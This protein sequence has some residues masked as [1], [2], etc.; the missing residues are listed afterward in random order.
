MWHGNHVRPGAAHRSNRGLE[1]LQGLGIGMKVF[2]NF[3]YFLFF[4]N[5]LL[6]LG[7][8]LSRLL[9]SCLLGTWL[10][11]RIDRTI[12]QNG[13][14]GAD[15]GF[16][17]WIGMLYVDHYH[18]NPVL[19]SFCHILIT[20]HKEKK[21][22]QTTKYW[23]LN[24]S[25][26][27]LRICALRGGENRPP[28]RVRSSSEELELRHQSSDAFPGRRLPG[29]GI[30]PADKMSS[31]GKVT[32]V[33]SGK[34]YQQIFQAEVQL[35]H[36]LAATRKRAAEH[37]VTLKCGKIPMMKKVETPEGEVMSPRQQKW[38][39]S[40]PNNWIME[41]PVLHR[42][43]E[44]AKRE[45]ARESEST[46]AAREV[47]G[48]MDTVVPEK[49]S[50][51]TFQRRAEHKRRSFENALASFQE[52]IAQVGKEM[53]AL[54]VDTA[55]LFLKKL[56]ESDEE[57][58]RL[59]L[60]MEN[61]T[62]LEDYTI[63]ALLELWDK[64]ARQFLLQKQE[65]KELDE[66]L[67]SLEFS[68]VN[69]LKG[70]LKKYAEVIEKTSYLMRPDVYKLIN[71]EAMVMN[72]ALL[73][74]RKALAQL[75]VNLMES[76]LQQ[77]LDIRHRWQSLVDTWKDLKK[78]A[79]LQSFSE[80]MASESIHTPLAVV[81]ELEVML[82]TQN[83]LQQK[84]LKHLCTICDLLPPNYSKTQLTEWHS[85]L[86]SMNKELDTYHVDCMMRIRLLYEKTWQECLMLVQNCKKQLLD[87]KAFTE[88][89]AETLVNQF[90]FQMVGAL[91]GKVEEDLEL[92]DKSFETLADQTEWQSS[93]LFRYFQ[94]AV[95]LWEA[96][97]KEL[98]V[99]ELELEKRMEQHQQKH[100]LESQVQEA[101]LDRLLDQLRQQSDKEI[102][103]FHLEKVKDYLKNMK[104]RYE[105]FHTLLTKEVMEY[106]AIILKE[107]NSYSS[108]LSQYFFVREIFEQ[109]LAGEVIFKFRQPE[110][111][112][113]PFQ[114]RMRKL[115]KKQGSKEDM[116]RSEES[117]SSG[118]SAATSVEEMEEE[119]DQEM[120]SFITEEV[121]GQQ[122][123]FPLHAEMDES[124]EG[125]I[126]GLEEMQVERES[127]LNPSLNEENVKG[128]GEEKEESQEEDEKEEEEEEKLE[129]EKEEK[130]A[131][132]EQESLS[133]GEEEDKEEGLE[134]TYYEDMESF[135]VSSG[136]TYF[137]FVPLEE[138]EHC[139]KSHSTFSAMF[140]S[141]TSSAKFIE[142]VTIPSRLILEIK[143]QLRA[144]FFE[145]LEKWFDQCSLN[146]RVTVATKINELDSELELHLHLHQ[147]RAQQI[148]KDIHNV[149]AA[150]L[151]LHQE[152]L[153]S[154]CAGVTEALKK[155]QLMFCQF[156]EEQNV[157]SKNFRLKIYDMEHI[158][159]N[160][161]R[162][163]K[164]VILSNTLHQEL[165]SY[166]DV[167]Q[168]S[169]RSFRQYL[170]ESLG[171]LR[172]SNIE[173]IKHCRLFSEGGNFSPKEI[174]SLCHRLEKEAA[175]IEL[176]DSVIMLNMEKME[177]EYLDQANDVINKFE[178]KFHNLSVD[179]IF[180]EK[181]QRLLTNLQV[182]I[183]CQVAKSNSQTNG[184]NFSLQ[185]LQNKI[186]T[187]QESRGE[188]TTVT[189][190]E[191]LGFVQTWKEKLSQRIQYLNCSLD[192][193]SMT[194][195][196]FTN[197][198]LKDLEQESD[199]LTSSEALEE[200]A[201]PDVVTPESFA[202]LSRMGKPLIED[203]AVDVIRKILQLPNTK[204]P[205]HHCDKDRSQTGFKRH[206]C[207]PENSGKKAVP[208]ASG[209]S[210][211]SLQTTHPPLSHS[212]TRHPKPNRMERKYQV[213]G[214]KPP[215]P[216]EDFKGIIL[217]LLWES[218]ENLLTVAEEF[219]RKEKRPVTR[220]DCMYD[221]FDQ[222]AE[223]ISKKIL[224]Y[225]SQANKYHNSCL[226]ELRIQMR[227]FEELLP[228]VC[229]LVMENFKE[230]HWKKFC[231]SV[232]EIR[233]Q[234]EGQQKQLEKRKDKNAQKL[235][236]NLGHPIH[237][238]D[239]ESLHLSEDKRQEELDSMIRMNREKLEECTRRNG[240]VFITNLA[241]FTEKFL[242]QL[243]E[244]VTIDDVQVARMEPPKQKIS[245]LIRRKLAG[246]SLKEE[247]EKPLIERGSRK[248]PG[249]KPT[250]VTVQNKILL[251]PTSSISTTKTTLGHLAAVEARDA[252]YLKYLAS[253]EEEL[254]R[255][256]DDSTSQMKEAQRW[257]DSW[258][259]SLHTI[260]G[261]YV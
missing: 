77:E 144:G 147:P 164:L 81:K 76:T 105:C 183:K 53:E 22:Q 190:E 137:V 259:Q 230:H 158:F 28:A 135:T 133:V 216:A 60:K 250:E 213:L 109:N 96:H 186:K 182:H 125:S 101:H 41:N 95:Q 173:F 94:E 64:V 188:K 45:K 196:V 209:T 197:T 201:K 222:C 124:K 252:V 167:T 97:Q 51:S 112:E 36:S 27:S 87:W 9:I 68:R 20:N 61:D 83:V 141:D 127:S 48:L 150:E 80:F 170:E 249:I 43:K 99:Q 242:L 118:T 217:T 221:T 102:L 86:N 229:W 160:A 253:F 82:K 169:L 75:F 92:L 232:K 162:S 52:E 110:A 57:M 62:N 10:I 139:R 89:E 107:L 58:N 172:Y 157:R 239:M 88:E 205:T 23:C 126:Q 210:A 238:Q 16:S 46:I 116:S 165:L 148:E 207:R 218:N 79:L 248:W 247:S 261:L 189:T 228:Q 243:D 26:E 33:P 260:Q 35:V 153:D 63:Q 142:Q 203:P 206:R 55:G 113:K 5:V 223:N 100:S 17:A 3:N 240:Q 204:W 176:V 152:R 13:Y 117:I 121:L 69:K 4:Y 225:Q 161:T 111:H 211:S 31:V 119:N 38:M 195:L 234:F 98:L 29:R 166:V 12:M 24:H 11:A 49:I 245:M 1:M 65:I 122:K 212:L 85:S 149:R 104:S 91:Q 34:A 224:E 90:F 151:L 40:L 56:T 236:L 131:E 39:L 18:T 21:L 155:E 114:K 177:N 198:I 73:G 215:P 42:E 194:E 70:V 227:R 132:E 154:H 14:E 37:S 123:K 103:A 171:K 185:Q 241:A 129:E 134:E 193:V 84:R 6:G 108:N 200:E 192:R 180:I 178:S 67:H 163:Q 47:R 54:I 140:I 32:Q 254:K 257:K 244:V 231:T 168:V 136:N 106:P 7:A 258:K 219:Y 15:M 2:H 66:A 255:I 115:R 50:T 44:R 59:F 156:Q 130:E 71:K 226:I 19:V 145:H 138:E 25:A 174:N 233:G 235:H 93:D 208:S 251:R 237:F 175:R 181:T 256:Q 246:L 146:T 220:P 78:Q 8:C 159:L 128:Q 187:C 72:Y 184:L 199:I 214:D 143:K 74:N 30:Q 191:L 202:Q 120:E 179:L